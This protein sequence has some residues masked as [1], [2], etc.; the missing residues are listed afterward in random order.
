MTFELIRICIR[1]PIQVVKYLEISL[2]LE[3]SAFI[4][5]QFVDSVQSV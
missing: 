3:N 4:Y 5:P 2:S 1:T